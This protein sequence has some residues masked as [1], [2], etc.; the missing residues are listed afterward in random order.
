MSRRYLP[1]AH[2]L[3]Y[4]NKIPASLVLKKLHFRA[5]RPNRV[6]PS[7]VAAKPYDAPSYLLEAVSAEKVPFRA[8]RGPS[9][10]VFMCLDAATRI[11]PLETHPG[12]AAI[13]LR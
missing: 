8:E 10:P 6:R 11:A 1:K 7:P 2:A 4:F 5:R 9:A 12:L 3:R 13:A